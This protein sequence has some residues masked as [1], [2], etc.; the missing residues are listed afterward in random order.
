MSVFIKVVL[1]PCVVVSYDYTASLTFS[2][3]LV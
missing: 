2:H 1:L 3:C